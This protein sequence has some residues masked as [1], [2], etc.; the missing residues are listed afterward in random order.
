MQLRNV[1]NH[2]E[3]FLREH[4]YLNEKILFSVDYLLVGACG[5]DN[6]AKKLEKCP[7]D[8]ITIGHRKLQLSE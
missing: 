5:E 6:G 2:L 7:L 8:Q 3:T 4:S 1:A